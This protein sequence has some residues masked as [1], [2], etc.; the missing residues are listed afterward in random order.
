MTLPTFYLKIRLRFS[1]DT[2]KIESQMIIIQTCFS[3]LTKLMGDTV[4][5][6]KAE[7]K[8]VIN[9]KLDK[10]E[11]RK[12]QDEHNEEQTLKKQLDLLRQEF[13]ENNKSI[14]HLFKEYKN[15]S[16]LLQATVSP[17]LPQNSH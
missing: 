10:I 1:L 3:K 6:T 11:L 16:S 13:S 15:L 2:K 7:I 17:W 8:T 14:N 5:E 4:S 12:H 9:A